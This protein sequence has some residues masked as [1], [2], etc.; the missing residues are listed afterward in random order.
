[1]RGARGVAAIAWAQVRIA[2][3]R[4][5]SLG[6]G[7]LVAALC[8]ALLSSEAG[9]SSARVTG[10]VR[11]NFRAAYDILVRP[12]GAETAFER[13]HHV[14]DDGFLSALFGGI[15][16]REYRKIRSLAG[17]SVAAPVANVGSFIYQ[18][19]VFVPFPRSV[20]RTGPRLFRVDLNWNVHHGLSRYPGASLY[21]YWSPKQIAFMPSG[22]RYQPAPIGRER[23]DG[24]TQAVCAG[25]DQ[26][27]PP[28][29]GA[30]GVGSTASGIGADRIDP[31]TAALA[32]SFDCAAKLVTF[33]GRRVSVNEPNLVDAE[34][35]GQLG[36]EI[37]FDLPVLVAGIDP[38]A[39]N[40]LVGLKAAMHSGDYLSESA[41]L[42]AP[43]DVPGTDRRS[44]Q[45]ADDTRSQRPCDVRSYPVIAS[46]RTY[47]DEV[48]DLTVQQLT[49]PSG[50][51]L[52]RELASD[53]NAYAFVTHLPGHTRARTSVSPTTAWH[54]ALTHFSSELGFDSADGSGFSLDYWRPSA[55]HDRVAPNETIIPA[56]VRND[57]SDWI[58]G[59]SVAG[60]SIAPPGSAD[61]WYR[62]LTSYTATGA[63]RTIDGRFTSSTPLPRLTGTFD[64]SRLRGFSALSRVP[65]QSFYP[66]T[67][68]GADPAAQHALHDTAL[69]PS[70]NLAGYLSQ[71]PLLLTTLTGA[72]ALENGDGD[73]GLV[74][75]GVHTGGYTK[76]NP[77]APISTIQVRVA[78]V[79]GPNGPSLTRIDQVATGIAHQ[80]GL[81]VDITAGSSPTSEQIALAAGA[82]G[83][84]RLLVDQDWVKEGVAAQIIGALHSRD[85]GLLALSLLVCG[86]AV[87]AAASA[88]LRTRRR[89]IATLRA[90]GWA[91]PSIFML[92]IGE[93]MLV[94]LAAGV[95]GCLLA[96][97]LTATGVLRIEALRIGLIVPVALALASGAALLPAWRAASAAP[98]D[99][100]RDPV[101][102]TRRAPSVRSFATYALANILQVPGRS[103]L[104]LAT[105]T[106]GIAGLT[107]IVG[108]DLAFTNQVT[109]NL[110]GGAVSSSVDGVDLVS[111]AI[112]ALLG[113]ASLAGVIHADQRQRR[114]EL[115]TL[116]ALGWNNRSI[117]RTAAEENALLGLAGSLCGALAGALTTA[118]TGAS[119]R[120]AVLAAAI[121]LCAGGLLMLLGCAA[122]AAAKDDGPDL[123]TP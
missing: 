100:L 101:R 20:S 7:V 13:A 67:V 96:L 52:P 17:V 40:A 59:G 19:T 50:A 55:T 86:L 1:V 62:H 46:T 82:F 38:T 8:F 70:S 63:P 24:S 98:L 73:I 105:M 97:A 61:T 123:P 53:R 58:A 115:S 119:G 65:L 95:I 64:P 25:F 76:V 37:T 26:S 79:T 30:T 69:G 42:S 35:S 32:P 29:A 112:V 110:L 48:A 56:A 54:E 41:G 6:A 57:P 120:G 27:E 72:I 9:T 85:I 11:H 107:F 80:T 111:A 114:A 106:L 47:L 16:M 12:A 28:S 31:Y 10:A 84:P 77:D 60:L 103:L 3:A 83:Q 108:I 49:V 116:R 4:A 5:L 51:D 75:P 15:T 36:A 33:H 113:A 118:G 44:S 22:D 122:L 45:C 21:V 71:P 68:T 81:T 117:I 18:Q 39:E 23:V 87:T 78:G 94:G 88:A 109:G 43:G 2:P 99:A 90:L 93:V 91:H 14:V 121:G 34:L 102:A 74:R 89:E 92:V 66:P 104:S